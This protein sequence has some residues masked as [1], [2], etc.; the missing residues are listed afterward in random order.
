MIP[1]YLAPLA[2]HLWQSTLFG[3]AAGLLTLAFRKNRPVVRYRLWLA[4]SL[5]FLLPFS[6]LIAFAGQVHWRSAAA[7]EPTQIAFAVTEM[8][9]PFGI[10]ERTIPSEPVLIQ[11]NRTPIVLFFLWLIGA[12]VSLAPWVS[13][14]RRIRRILRNSRPVPL[15]F[16]VPVLSCPGAMEPGIFGVIRPV[17]LLPEGIQ[18]RLTPEEFQTILAHERCHVRRRDNLTATAH[19]I[20]E[21]LF[22]FHPLV[23]WIEGRMTAEQENACDEEVIRFGAEPE[24]YAET[25]LKICRLYL[26]SPLACVAKVTGADL[27]KRVE[28][29]IAGCPA[30]RV[31]VAGKLLIT[32]MCTAVFA[33]PVFSGVVQTTE[34]PKQTKTEKTFEVAAVKLNKS[35]ASPA[36]ATSNVSLQ[37]G[38]RFSPTGG[39]FVARNFQLIDYLSWSYNLSGFERD[40]VAR[41]LTGWAAKDRFDIEA[42]A[43]AILASKRCKA[44]CARSWPINSSWSCT[45][46]SGK[47][48]C[49][50][51]CWKGRENLARNLRSIQGT[52]ASHLR[53]RLQKTCAGTESRSVGSVADQLL[54][55]KRDLPD[56]TYRCGTSR[57]GWREIR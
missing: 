29:I 25:I 19:M 43:M 42:R 27:R 17:L 50:P 15:D 7:V 41:Q 35:G 18:Q 14:W 49:S 11:P 55:V 12:A 52:I 13:Q 56:S 3:T 38:G 32:A 45:M 51:W 6:L 1:A 16:P 34:T 54:T 57:A 10:T 28:R 21:T 40:A 9:Q 23:W 22:W 46:K 5:K 30:I 8:S 26:A 20:V 44:C 37:P 47:V 39:Y 4:A 36:S 48:Q 24:V 2:N 31:S 53:E 33:I